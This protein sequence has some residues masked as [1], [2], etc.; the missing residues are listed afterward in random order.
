S[1]DLPTA[2]RE[3]VERAAAGTETELTF[4]VV[5]RPQA[6]PARVEEHV[7]LIGQEAVSNAVRHGRA[8]HVQVTLRY[9]HDR[10]ALH[11][12]D[13]G[14]GFD[15]EVARRTS[16]HYGL[17]SMAERIEQVRGSL[18]IVSR[19]GRGTEVDATVPTTS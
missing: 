11:V 4:E 14:C 6:A 19:P 1:R 5:G 16:G 12:T 15:V 9:E 3:A 2:L 8:R 17:V 10:L 7:L 13:D 18:D